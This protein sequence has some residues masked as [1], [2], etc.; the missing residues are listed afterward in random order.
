MDIKFPAILSVEHTAFQLTERLARA[1]KEVFTV[2]ELTDGAD[3][4]STG[5]VDTN[6]RTD[7]AGI[8]R[9]PDMDITSF[10]EQANHFAFGDKAFIRERDEQVRAGRGLN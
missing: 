2:A 1:E 10:C 3:F 7:V 9:R 5:V 6:P 4:V 8:F